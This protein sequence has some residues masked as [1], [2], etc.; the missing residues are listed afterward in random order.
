MLIQHFLAFNRNGGQTIMNQNGRVNFFEC[1]RPKLTIFE[2]KPSIHKLA[3]ET[4][5]RT[6]SIYVSPTLSMC[7]E[8]TQVLKS[9]GFLVRASVSDEASPNKN[10][11]KMMVQRDENM[12]YT[13][14]P[15]DRS[16]R[17][18]FVSDVHY[19]LKTTRN[20]FEN[21]CWNNQTRNL[22]ASI[23]RLL[24]FLLK[25]QVKLNT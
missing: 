3:Y 22:H 2:V 19:L 9:I 18:Y 1:L 21:S 12:F 17:V 20:C 15:F 6:H 14:N 7:I 11:Y 16:R 4:I 5:A 13:V 23:E 10:F 8:A 25:S 24:Q